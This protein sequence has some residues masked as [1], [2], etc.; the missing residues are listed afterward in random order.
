MLSPQDNELLTRTNQGTSM[1]ALMRR[2]WIPALLAWELPHADSDPLRVR[3]LGEDMVAFRDTNGQVGMIQN[4]CPHRGASLFFGRNEEAGIRCVYHGWKFDITGQCIDMP[5]EPA[6][7]DFRHKVRSVAYPTA[8][9]GGI[10]WVYMG[11]PALKPALP[12]LEWALVP[13][14]HRYLSKRIQQTNYAQAME[15]GI[16]SSHVSFLHKDSGSRR[17]DSS[18][19]KY[20]SSDGAPKFEIVDTS[21]GFVIG[22]RRKAEEDSYYW[23]ITQWL[24]PFFQ[25]IPPSGGGPISGHAWVPIDDEHCYTY[26]M[27]WHP[28]RPLTEAEVDWVANGKGV[29]ALKIPGTFRPVRNATNDYM[30]DRQAQRSGRSFT[31]ITGISEQDTAVQESMGPIYDRTSEHLGAA[32]AAIIQMRRRLMRAAQELEQGIDPPALD[33]TVF[34]VRS[35]SMVL[36]RAEASWPEAAREAMTAAPDRFFVSVA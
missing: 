5:N 12:D 19:S 4:N 2:Y 8:E 13:D 35:V 9:R 17:R 6:E 31:G 18:A 1:G 20:L 10:I 16:D 3:L 28:G 21:Y 25:M 22:A 15:G 30:I 26:S 14:D 32:D 36:P 29:H 24:F 34:R 11:P 33:P 7:S 23:R 27:T